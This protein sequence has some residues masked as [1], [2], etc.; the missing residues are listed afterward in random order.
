MASEPWPNT[1]NYVALDP[2]TV[3]ARIAVVQRKVHTEHDFDCDLSGR[4]LTGT[5]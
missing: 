1:R 3:P 4:L 2:Q 5:A